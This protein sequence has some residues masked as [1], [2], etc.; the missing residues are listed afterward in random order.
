[1]DTVEEKLNMTF[2]EVGNRFGFEN[3]TA[4]FAAFT[5]VKVKWIRT[6]KSIEMH[7]TDYLADAPGGV[8][9]GIAECIF[10]KIKGNDTEY[11]DE[12][13]EWLT[14]DK[15]LEENQD[16]YISRNRMI[17]TDEGMYKNLEESI[18]RLKENG[19][20]KEDPSKIKIFWSTDPD[21]NQAGASSNLMKTVIINKRFDTK[22]IEDSILDLVVL[23]YVCY[24]LS[25]FKDSKDERA[26]KLEETISSYP[27]FDS[28]IDRIEKMGLDF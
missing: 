2:Q 5:D 26:E 6:M 17:D 1:M 9:R 28:V 7:V 20:L 15:V 19:F 21:W 18:D 13:V 16:T 3:V 23:K 10:G 25:N 24:A 12:V 22:E 27:G 11:S 4:T 8:L 14:S